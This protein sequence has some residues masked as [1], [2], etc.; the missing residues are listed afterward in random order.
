MLLFIIDAILE[1]LPLQLVVLAPPMRARI[2]ISPNERSTEDL[3]FI[4]HTRTKEDIVLLF[5]GRSK[6]CRRVL[7]Q[8]EEKLA[9]SGAH[10]V[11]ELGTYMSCQ[12]R[13]RIRGC[14]PVRPAS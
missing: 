13:A 2:A 9:A 14:P 1:M 4:C 5:D 10:L 12:R 3:D 7:E 8:A 11:A 6:Q